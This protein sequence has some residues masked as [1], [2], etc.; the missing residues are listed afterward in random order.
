[1]TPPNDLVL[2][3]LSDVPNKNKKI[4]VKVDEGQGTS[5]DGTVRYGLGPGIRA[6]VRKRKDEAMRG[7]VRRQVKVTVWLKLFIV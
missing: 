4:K 5:A 7:K 1:M 6:S 3:N 2:T